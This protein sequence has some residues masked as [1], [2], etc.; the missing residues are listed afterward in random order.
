LVSSLEVIPLTIKTFHVLVLTAEDCP[1]HSDF[2]T[3]I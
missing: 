2:F 3:L 1:K